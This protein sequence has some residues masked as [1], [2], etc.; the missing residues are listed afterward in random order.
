MT[1]PEEKPTPATPRLFNAVLQFRAYTTRAGYRRLDD[2]LAMHQSLY[3][4]AL[5][6]SGTVP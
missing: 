2:V 4:A 3:N 6:F 1:A 5:V